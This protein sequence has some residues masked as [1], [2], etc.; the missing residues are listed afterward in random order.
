WAAGSAIFIPMLNDWALRWMGPE[1]SPIGQWGVVFLVPFVALLPATAAMGATFPAMER[2]WAQRS[3]DGECVARIYAANTS[4][5][6][7]GIFAGAFAL[8]PALGFRRSLL[9][10]A[11]VSCACGVGALRIGR[12]AGAEPGKAAPAQPK[13]TVSAR[14]YLT[15]FLTGLLGIGFQ[16]VGIR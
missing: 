7:P 14:L 12:D 9:V 8:M 11:G 5:A 1:P 15:L 3:R 4:G 16:L 2:S 6:V 13:Q 10:L